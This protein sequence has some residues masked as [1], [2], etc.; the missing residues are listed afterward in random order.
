MHCHYERGKNE[1]IFL[2]TTRNEIFWLNCVFG[3]CVVEI[4]FIKIMLDGCLK[5]VILCPVISVDG[6]SGNTSL[7]TT[8]EHMETNIGGETQLSLLLYSQ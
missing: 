3:Y 5:I 4:K 1:H 6:E 2:P 8:Q 7:T